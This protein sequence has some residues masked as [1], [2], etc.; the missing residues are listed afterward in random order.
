METGSETPMTFNEKAA[1]YLRDHHEE[2][3]TSL[4]DLR[5]RNPGNAVMQEVESLG[6][7]GAIGMSLDVIQEMLSRE[8]KEASASNAEFV[9]A[10]LQSLAI[11]NYLADFSKNELTSH[12]LEE[13]RDFFLDQV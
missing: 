8:I 10:L 9:V 12:D 11:R 4:L 1:K 6:G 13:L 7:I 5:D 3:M 2:I